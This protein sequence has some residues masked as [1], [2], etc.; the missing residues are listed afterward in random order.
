LG[1]PPG[2]SDAPRDHHDDRLEGQ[3]RSA[4]GTKV[5]LRRDPNGQGGSLTIHFYSDE[6]LQSLYERII[7]DD[8]W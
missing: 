5:G 8:L 6:E 4:L 2:K 7:G 1:P 3:F